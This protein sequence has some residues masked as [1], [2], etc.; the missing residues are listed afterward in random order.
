MTLS[1]QYV[2]AEALAR[3]RT[4]RSGVT[5]VFSERSMNGNIERSEK[6]ILPGKQSA[7]RG[8]KNKVEYEKSF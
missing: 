1:F 7:S 5:T 8:L 2:V 3:F 6:S 4:E